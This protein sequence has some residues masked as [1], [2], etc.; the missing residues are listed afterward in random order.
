MVLDILASSK[1]VRRRPQEPEP[2]DELEALI[3]EAGTPGPEAKTRLR[4]VGRAC[5]FARSRRLPRLRWRERR[6]GRITGAVRRFRVGYQRIEGSCGR[7]ALPQ[8][9]SACSDPGRQRQRRRCPGL[10][11]PLLG[12]PPSRM[13]PRTDPHS[14]V[15]AAAGERRA[16][17]S[18]CAGAIRKLP[19]GRH[20]AVL[21]GRD[22]A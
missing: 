11:D 15:S 12:D 17:R 18:R 13:G 2:A 22:A 21:A 19:A 14:G 20:T 5:R 7:A 3:E 10:R 8:T 1:L 6:R 16:R 4:G 9:P